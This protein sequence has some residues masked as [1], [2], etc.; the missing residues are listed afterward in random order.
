MEKIYRVVKNGIVIARFHCD[1]PLA[2]VSFAEGYVHALAS[3]GDEISTHACK[4]KDGYEWWGEDFEMSV[5]LDGR[6]VTGED[7]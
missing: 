7:F 3:L 6:I 2:A 5:I 4:D 1:T